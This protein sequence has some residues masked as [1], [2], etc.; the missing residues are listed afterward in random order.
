MF[1]WLKT[2][3]V[4]KKKQLAIALISSFAKGKPEFFVILCQPRTGST[5]LHTYLN[6]HPN[7]MSYGEDVRS[8]NK[9]VMLK[10][11]PKSIKAVG[12]KLFY[13]DL[14]QNIFKKIIT[15]TNIKIVHLV[16]QDLL[17]QF[18]SL[19]RAQ[20][21]EVWSQEKEFKG[22]DGTAIKIDIQEFKSFEQNS[23][24]QRQQMLSL[25]EQHEMLQVSYEDLCLRPEEILD[26]IQHFLNAKPRKLFS[27]LKKQNTDQLELLVSNHLELLKAFPD[28][29]NT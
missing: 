27:L 22:A 25:F 13:E 10:K 7:I 9:Q 5:L 16:R 1:L 21:T 2:W 17:R 28:K 18:I 20:K 23:I 26:G 6:S 14:E 24:Q 29:F 12:F 4:I 3:I 19:K 15:K 11:F 8:G